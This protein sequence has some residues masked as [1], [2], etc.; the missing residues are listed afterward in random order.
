MNR[1][2]ITRALGGLIILGLG[3]IF[4]LNN[5]GVVNAE[6]LTND[7]WPLAIIAAGILLLINNLR[8]WAGLFLVVLGGAYQLKELGAVNFEPWELIWPLVIV[9]V[10]ASILFRRSYVGAH[11]SKAER[12]DLT[13]ILA[14]T[15]STNASKK[16]KEAN[17]TAIMGGGRLDLRKA[18]IEDGALVEVFG[19]WGGV[20]IVVPKNVVIKNQINNILAGTED[21]TNQETDKNSPTLTIAGDL[22]MAG[23]GIRNSPSED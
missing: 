21:K 18:T 17:V 6:A 19:F 1:S 15:N 3:L 2:G 8:N 22:I 9:F 5:L 16:F 7:W 20:E 11:A 10:G 14:G 12:D 23:V 13:A 4:L